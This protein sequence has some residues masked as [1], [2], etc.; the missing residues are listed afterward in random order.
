MLGDDP[1]KLWILCVA[2]DV[3]KIK[4]FKVVRKSNSMIHTV[5]YARNS[6]PVSSLQDSGPR[7][8]H[9]E[10]LQ[11][12]R[13]HPPGTQRNYLSGEAGKA[14]RGSA[15]IDMA[16]GQNLVLLDQNSW[17]LWVRKPH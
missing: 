12:F 5:E 17:D 1:W 4:Y 11:P 16:M 2:G 8:G 15:R 9:A 6:S 14:P 3:L 13:D 7:H 10:A